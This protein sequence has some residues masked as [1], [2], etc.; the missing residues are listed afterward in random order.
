MLVLKRTTLI[1]GRKD[2]LIKRIEK[3]V[4]SFETMRNSLT[5]I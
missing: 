1:D 4:T 3:S 5:I 2:N